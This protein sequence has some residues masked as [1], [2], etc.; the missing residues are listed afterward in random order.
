MRRVQNID[1]V[2]STWF[3]FV[4]FSFSFT[5]TL[6]D[7]F[8]LHLTFSFSVITMSLVKSNNTPTMLRIVSESF[9]SSRDFLL[10]GFR[11]SLFVN[12]VKPTN[13]NWL[14]K[15][16]RW[17]FAKQSNFWFCFDKDYETFRPKFPSLGL[18]S[19]NIW[20]KIFKFTEIYDKVLVPW[21]NLITRQ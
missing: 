20:L 5:C 6:L 7:F 16:V 15:E 2:S 1:H 21:V 11:W 18:D 9:I 3:Q 4:F 13:Q 8:M 14:L 10:K 17:V 19:K 12:L